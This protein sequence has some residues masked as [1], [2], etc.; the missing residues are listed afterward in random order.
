MLILG[1]INTSEI[2]DLKK[3]TKMLRT[4]SMF[5]VRAVYKSKSL[6][7]KN[8]VKRLTQTQTYL[9][10]TYN[11]KQDIYKLIINILKH[12]NITSNG[13]IYTSKEQINTIKV[14]KIFKLV[15]FGNLTVPK[16]AIF[17]EA[18]NFGIKQMKV[19]NWYGC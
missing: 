19:M 7:H 6:I 4:F 17:N 11:T 8:A 2:K 14:D 10:N 18:L 16:N 3:A 5:Y 12:I 13:I 9:N 1:N 15:T